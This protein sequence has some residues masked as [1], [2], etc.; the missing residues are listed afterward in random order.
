MPTPVSGVPRL[1]LRLEGLVVLAAATMAYAALDESWGF[2]ALFFLVPDV[3]LAGYLA[4][5]QAGA[6]TYNL[7]HTYVSPATLG[8]LVYLGAV[9]NG[10][11]LCLIWVAHIGLDRALGLGLKFATAF[12]DTHLGSIGRGNA[13]KG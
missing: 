4:G 6:V 10:W 11:P 9:P 2:F 1:L 3:T 13:P 5:P 12:G 8:A 7:A